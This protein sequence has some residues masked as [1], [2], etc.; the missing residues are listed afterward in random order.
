[1]EVR[2]LNPFTDGEALWLGLDSE[3]L[4]RKVFRVVDERL[5]NSDHVTAGLTIFDPGESSSLHNHPDSEEVDFIIQG[6]GEVVSGGERVPFGEHS[7]MFIPKGVEHQH[8]NIGEQPMWL[9]W[10]Y[11]P[12][13]EL[14]TT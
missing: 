4:R 8:V 10:M 9:I 3:G 12:R 2:V 13:G 7:F 6:H 14:P 1:M 11:T 5:V